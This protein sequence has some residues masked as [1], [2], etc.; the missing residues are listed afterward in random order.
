MVVHREK[1]RRIAWSLYGFWNCCSVPTHTKH[2]LCLCTVHCRASNDTKLQYSD[3]KDRQQRYK[4]LALILFW[5]YN[6]FVSYLVSGAYTYH[7][8]DWAQTNSII[9]TLINND[10]WSFHFSHF[11]VCHNISFVSPYLPL[12]LSAFLLFKLFYIPIE[13]CLVHN[14]F[15]NFNIKFIKNK[16]CDRF[17]VLLLLSPF[18]DWFDH[19]IKIDKWFFAVVSR[20]A[21]HTRFIVY[22]YYHTFLAINVCVFLLA[23]YCLSVQMVI[24]YFHVHINASPYRVNDVVTFL[25]LPHLLLLLFWFICFS[26]LF[27]IHIKINHFALNNGAHFVF[28]WTHVRRT[29]GFKNYDNN[30]TADY[31]F[32]DFTHSIQH[33]PQ[34]LI[35]ADNNRLLTIILTIANLQH[36]MH[37][38]ECAR[39][40][41]HLHQQ[42]TRSILFRL[43]DCRMFEEWASVIC[44]FV[45]VSFGV[46][47]AA[48]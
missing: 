48:S 4:F 45:Q 33:L 38:N 14:L 36:N 9:I 42:N 31:K 47:C 7:S 16:Y 10:N 26:S 23:F 5:Y 44:L 3:M 28:Q 39:T 13:P 22:Y 2:N 21:I 32:Y 18:F 25:M 27:P 24:N 41:L 40:P 20:Y 43:S 30:R 35:C 1:F 17:C 19:E 6:V 34:H 37:P 12:S 46:W 29:K 15:A 11:C 8:I